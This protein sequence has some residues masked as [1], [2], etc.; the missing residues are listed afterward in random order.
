MPTREIQLRSATA[1]DAIWLVVFRLDAHRYALPLSVTERVVRAVAVTPLPN[2]PAV[3]LGVIDVAG[4]LVPVFDLRRRFRLPQRRLSPD[5]HLVLAQTAYGAV[6]L[7]TDL[8]EGVIER[9]HVEPI[10][11]DSLVPGLDVVDGVVRCED[12]LVLIQNLERFL[13]AE[14]ARELEVALKHNTVQDER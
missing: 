11:A 7:V 12:G 13:S 2:T 9:D 5:D 1:N 10:P 14:E 6:A 4:Q 3:V 8:V